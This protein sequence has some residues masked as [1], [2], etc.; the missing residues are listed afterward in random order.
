MSLPS[1]PAP[2]L[3]PAWK[4]SGLGRLLGVAVL[5]ACLGMCLLLQPCV[6]KGTDG[7]GWVYSVYNLKQITLA[8]VDYHDV[9]KKLPPAVVRDKAGRP[10]YSWRVLL[11]PFVEQMNLYNEFHL[12]EPWDSEHNKK[13]LEKMPPCYSHLGLGD[14]PPN[15]TYYQVF[16]GPGTAFERPGLTLKDF[17][18]GPANT[19]L[20]VEAREPVPWSKPADLAYDPNGPLPPLGGQF[21]KP[22]HFLCREVGRRPGFAAGFADGTARFLRSDADERD[23]RALITRNGGEEVDPAG[24]E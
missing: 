8:L 6:Q 3:P 14:D 5:L 21:G 13:L 18:D 15:K 12:D 20:V 17:P 11:L 24:L 1:Q 4:P 2:T 16:V 23:M 7:E 9:Y 19:L 22:I 10:L